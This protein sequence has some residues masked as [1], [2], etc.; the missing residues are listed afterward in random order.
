MNS[1]SNAFSFLG[2]FA[3]CCASVLGFGEHN[4]LW[5]PFALMAIVAVLFGAMAKE[6]K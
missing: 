5:I 3:T 4:A 1:T 2:G 6:D